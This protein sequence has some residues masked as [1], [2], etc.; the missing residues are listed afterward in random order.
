LLQTARA[1]RRLGDKFLPQNGP[2]ILVLPHTKLN[3]G[4]AIADHEFERELPIRARTSL[5]EV[6]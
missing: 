2:Q 1:K 3:R 4:H 6:S 5:F